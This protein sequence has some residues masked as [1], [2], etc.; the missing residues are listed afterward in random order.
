MIRL[1]T[2]EEEK[3]VFASSPNDLV[4]VQN[5]LSDLEG[6]SSQFKQIAAKGL[7][8]LRDAIMVSLNSSIEALQ[9]TQ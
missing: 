1:R 4:R 3:Q 9:S 6:S 5:T 8:V 7:A 2:N